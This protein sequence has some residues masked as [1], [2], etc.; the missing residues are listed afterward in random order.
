MAETPMKSFAPQYMQQHYNALEAG[1]EQY[2]TTPISMESDE[3]LP[4]PRMPTVSVDVPVTS[5]QDELT[6]DAVN[7]LEQVVGDSLRL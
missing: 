6:Q 5:L 1:G 7:H 4:L 3:S 2:A